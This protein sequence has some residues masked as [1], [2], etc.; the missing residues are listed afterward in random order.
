MHNLELTIDREID[1]MLKY[2][3]TADELF[4]IKLIFYA[5]EEHDEYIVRFFS[6][7]KLTIDLKDLL[8]SL[9]EKGIIN[10]SYKIP[11]KGMVFKPQDVDFNK[12]VLDSLFQ[13][14]SDLGMELF[15]A[16]P[17][18]TNINGKMFSLRNVAKKFNS[19]DEFCWAYGKAIKFD[20]QKHQ[21][22]LDILDW[23]KEGN[24]IH[25]GI[26]DF[27]ISQQWQTYEL[28]KDG[29]N[30]TFDALESL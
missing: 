8:G 30:V 5:Q 26:C 16:Y 24:Y 19:M 21:E 3:L 25:S 20:L 23:A 27:V 18:Y 7:G 12:R 1:F 15:E 4:L 2:E 22:I 13:H 29:N 10:K 14:S 17:A 11:E 6:R 9:Q 28:M